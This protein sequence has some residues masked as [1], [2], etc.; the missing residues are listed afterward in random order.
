M[1]II[2]YQGIAPSMDKV[3][4]VVAEV[5]KF[6]VTHGWQIESNDVDSIVVTPHPK[7]E[8]ISIAYDRKLRFSGFTKTV[9]APVEIHHKIVVLFFEIKPLLKKLIIEDSTGYWDSFLE[10]NLKKQIK[11]IVIFP[12]V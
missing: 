6:S 12:E 2:A 3:H 1:I 5:Q 8:S 4:E 7:C 11:E 9:Y 10:A